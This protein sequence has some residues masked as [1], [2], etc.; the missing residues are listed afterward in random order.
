[1]PLEEAM[2]PE[3]GRVFLS[4][5]HEDSEYAARLREALLNA[6]FDVAWDRD[7]APGDRF[8][9]YID[10]AIEDADVMAILLSRKAVDSP[11]MAFQIGAMVGRREKDDSSTRLPRLVPVLIKDNENALG[12]LNQYQVIDASRESPEAAAQHVV[13]MLRK[14][15]SRGGSAVEQRRLDAESV[16]GLRESLIGLEAART[17]RAQA[18]ALRIGMALTTALVASVVG[19]LVGLVSV[20]TEGSLSALAAILG[21]FTA[22]FGVAIGFYFGRSRRDGSG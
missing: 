17:K 18:M 5:V 14:A 1:M 21:T 9:T 12:I 10:R 3:R 2:T 19:V 16:R 8:A 4:Y 6:G 20:D 15:V 22:L 13:K 11:W 7:I